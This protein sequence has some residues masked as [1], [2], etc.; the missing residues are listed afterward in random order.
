[1]FGDGLIA[2]T[3][4]SANAPSLAVYEKGG[5]AKNLVIFL[6]KKLDWGLGGE[7]YYYEFR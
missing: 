2:I 4:G 3:Q 5:L 7:F 6:R 1:L